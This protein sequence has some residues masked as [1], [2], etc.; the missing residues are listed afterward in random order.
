VRYLMMKGLEKP[1]SKMIMG[2]SWLTL[3]DEGKFHDLLDQYV[4]GGGTVI[5]TGRFYGRGTGIAQVEGMVRRWLEKSGKRDQVVIMDKCCHPFID[6]KGKA[7]SDRWRVSVDF[8]WEDL[9]FSLDNLGIDYFDIY[10]L[11]RDDPKIPVPDIMDAFEM[12]YRKGLVKAYGVSNWRK[13]RVE[14]ALAYGEKM[15]YRGLS[16]N[17][18]SYSLATVKVPRWDACV[19]ADDNYAKWHGTVDLPLLSWGAQAGG[20]FADIYDDTAPLNVKQAFFTPENFEK[21]KRAKELAAEKGV[22][23]INIAMAYVINQEFEAAAICAPQNEKEMASCL[24]GAALELTPA[25]IEY[26]SLRADKR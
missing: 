25:E 11:H 3:E 2:T 8:M 18:P 9:E 5:D 20:F 17:N 4:E 22:E 21:Q 26:L 12:M 10:E 7:H 23:P 16:C 19:Y 1:V 6:K 15:G 13:E 14:E 24:Q